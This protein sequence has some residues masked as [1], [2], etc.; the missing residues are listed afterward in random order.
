MN[1]NTDGL[2][3]LDVL[4]RQQSGGGAAKAYADAPEVGKKEGTEAGWPRE[5]GL[6]QADFQPQLRAAVKLI[7]SKGYKLD[8]KGLQG[9]RDFMLKGEGSVEDKLEAIETALAKDMPLKEALLNRLEGFSRKSLLDFL[10]EGLELG[11]D[12]SFKG[13]TRRNSPALE[14]ATEK[15]PGL[16]RAGRKAGPQNAH[17]SAGGRE[18][19]L[20]SD[21]RVARGHGGDSDFNKAGET[22]RL[23]K[24]MRSLVSLIDEEGDVSE[25]PGLSA[26]EAGTELLS[27]MD[28]SL[29]EL[30]EAENADMELLASYLTGA[31][32]INEGFSSRA[33]MM[34]LITPKLKAL[35]QDFE[36]LKAG[37]L[38][39]LSRLSSS[40]KPLSPEDG[41]K[42]LEKN[43]ERLDRAIMRS[44][45]SLYMDLKGERQLLKLSSQIQEARELLMG[46][47]AAAAKESLTGVLKALEKLDYV[48][49]IK[50]AL[51]LYEGPGEARP[52]SYIRNMRDVGEWLG[53]RAASFTIGE[54]GAGSLSTYMR[55]LGLGA[56]AENFEN[57]SL[58][59]HKIEPE[60]RDL[61]NLRGLLKQLSDSGA[62]PM[63]REAADAMLGR[64]EALDLKNKILDT[65][66][67]QT[68]SLELP[69]KMNGSIKS[70]KVFIQSPQHQRK[71]DWENFN[72]FFVL[73]TESMGELGIKVES[74][75][76]NLSVS[77][78]N[79][80][81]KRLGEDYDFKGEFKNEV[82]ELG[83]RLVK[84]ITEEWRGRFSRRA[85]EATGP[86]SG[87]EGRAQVRISGLEEGR[88]D[89][90]L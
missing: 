10:P 26:D 29:A 46:G 8:E 76:K 71:L 81:V 28:R 58:N 70:V 36:D 47:R 65:G 45:M 62:R 27:L 43:I 39:D 48:P 4:L 90:R 2:N 31:A 85:A 24:L 14:R 80:R 34:S 20:A 25:E 41:L 75:Q 82:E 61:V 59:R 64:I 21:P 33:V 44:E 30:S 67:A 50:K 53:A 42:T 60:T 37:L 7:E 87:T 38:K 11:S 54:G 77:I 68:L 52:S 78:I 35:K 79:D 63:D 13:G 51:L 83:F 84:M 69:L 1:I 56:E 3:R 88:F 23:D 15:E 72:M 5:A 86:A 49:S 9:L 18:S 32:S 55:K 89:L 17:L 16:S 73:S 12:P 19:A 57:M 22:E 6:K 40:E 74:V 66:E